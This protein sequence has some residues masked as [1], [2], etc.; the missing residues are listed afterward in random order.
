VAAADDDH[1]ARVVDHRH[2]DGVL[3]ASIPTHIRFSSPLTTCAAARLKGYVVFLLL[4][5]VNSPANRPRM[6]ARY[7][8]RRAYRAAK[9]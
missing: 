1:P 2:G 7:I 8:E 4:S 9:G 5:S 6:E 3:V